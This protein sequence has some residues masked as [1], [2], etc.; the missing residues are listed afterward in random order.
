MPNVNR[1]GPLLLITLALGLQHQASV[2]DVAPTNDVPNP[3]KT[4]APWGQLPEGRT[5]GALNAVAIDNDGESVWVATRCG[6]NPEIPP[7]GSP[8]AFDTCAGS[9]VPAVMQLDSSGNVLRTARHRM[10][11]AFAEATPASVSSNATT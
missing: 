7:G 8:F 3:Y 4:I 11:A 1:F 5:W 9:T 10:P 6:A 2:A